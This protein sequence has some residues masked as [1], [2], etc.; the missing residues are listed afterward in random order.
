MVVHAAQGMDLILTPS[1]WYGE[2]ESSEARGLQAALKEAEQTAEERLFVVQVEEVRR[3]SNVHR[4]AFFGWRSGKEELDTVMGRMAKLHEEM[5]KT[6]PIPP[7]T[8]GPT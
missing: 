7:G 8:Q 2:T 5:A 1:G 3:S 6:N 4:T